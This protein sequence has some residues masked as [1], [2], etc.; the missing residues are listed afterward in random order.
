MVALSPTRT[1]SPKKTSKAAPDAD[2][3]KIPHKPQPSSVLALICFRSLGMTGT[4]TW[5][6][7][8]QIDA[9]LEADEN[10]AK[11]LK[12]EGV[13][14]FKP[15]SQDVGAKLNFYFK[16]PAFN[17]R[18]M[19]DLLKGP[20]LN[21]DLVLGHQ[22]FLVGG[23]AGY[24]VQKAAVTRYSASVGFNQGAHTAALT[25]TNNFSIFAASFYNKVN[26]QVELG[27]NAA[28]DSKSS[29]TVGME[30]AAKYK[31][32]PTSFFKV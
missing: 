3:H 5:S 29:T 9:K 14:S 25:A 8:N 4:V 30:L 10:L 24:D 17:F 1:R 12:V 13:S 20:T 31:V 32:D 28:W 26:D 6:T 19:S 22:G 21:A 2:D 11:G 18:V 16:Q 7:F 27:A 23:E 15:D